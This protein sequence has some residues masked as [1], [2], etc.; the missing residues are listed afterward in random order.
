MNVSEPGAGAMREFSRDDIIGH[1]FTSGRR[2]GYDPQEVDTYLQRLGDYVGRLHEELARH[3]ASERAALDVLQGAQRVAD[4]TVATAQRDADRLR[5]NAADGLEH[6]RQEAQSTIDAA[7][8]DADKT[9]LSAR[10][11]AE[12]AVEQSR[13]QVAELEAAGRERLD[14]INRLVEEMKR[15]AADCASDFRSAGTR[16][17][18]MADHFQFDF[19]LGREE[20]SPPDG[21]SFEHP[22]DRVEVG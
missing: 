6:A 2:K 19:D 20:L 21:T 5:Q 3:Q 17:V 11:Q 18:E 9:L 8:A 4:D 10:L 13:S 22:A 14:A 7:R 1:R 15:A 12:A 16:L